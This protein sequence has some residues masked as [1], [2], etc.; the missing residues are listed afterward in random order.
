[1]KLTAA[2][3]RR[4][5]LSRSRASERNCTEANLAALFELRGGRIAIHP[6]ARDRVC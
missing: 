3:L 1:M 6:V 2:K 4:V 5:Q